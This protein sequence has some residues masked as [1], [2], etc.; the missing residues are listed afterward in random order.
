MKSFDS[1]HPSSS[2]EI[3]QFLDQVPLLAGLNDAAL[4]FLASNSA[5]IHFKERSVVFREGDFGKEMYFVFSG[6]VHVLKN[7]QHSNQFLLAEIKSNDFFGEMCLLET[8]PRS[9]SVVTIEPTRLIRIASLTLLKLYEKSPQQY[10]LLILNIAR[11]LS[12]RIR[13]LNGQIL[14]KEIKIRDYGITG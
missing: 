9:A 6:K 8:L 3:L 13:K 2:G 14:E 1:P 4:S 10:S 12:R 7:Y 5:E 11:D